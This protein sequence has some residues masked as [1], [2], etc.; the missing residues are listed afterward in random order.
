MQPANTPYVDVIVCLDDQTPLPPMRVSLADVRLIAVLVEAQVRTA[1]HMI[2][3]LR[4][5]NDGE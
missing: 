5:A 2:Q 4:A 3:L 1:Q